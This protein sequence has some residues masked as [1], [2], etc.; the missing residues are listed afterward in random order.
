MRRDRSK[1]EVICKKIRQFWGGE[2]REESVAE[3]K[4][5]FLFIYLFFWMKSVTFF[6]FVICFYL[7][8]LFIL[9]KSYGL[10]V[11]LVIFCLF[12]CLG[13]TVP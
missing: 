2:E 9:R 10:V 11:R 3:M 4:T 6:V 5:P 1:L 8:L 7:Y 13:G 12:S